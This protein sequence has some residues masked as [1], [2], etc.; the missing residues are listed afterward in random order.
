MILE[1][2]W[3]TD[4]SQ[5]FS[6][7]P[8]FYQDVNQVHLMESKNTFTAFSLKEGKELWSVSEGK[9]LFAHSLLC[10][11]FFFL[12]G[13]DIFSDQED[14]T[15]IVD[16]EGTCLKIES[17]LWP[18]IFDEKHVADSD[19]NVFES[20]VCV[21]VDSYSELI[22]K[23]KEDG[24]ITSLYES[25]TML[26]PSLKQVTDDSFI[27]YIPIATQPLVVSLRKDKNYKLNYL[28][29]GAPNNSNYKNF[30]LIKEEK[31]NDGFGIFDL[32]NGE[33]L[34]DIE[35]SSNVNELDGKIYFVA[36]ES[37]TIKVWSRD[38]GVEDI[39]LEEYGVDVIYFFTEKYIIASTAN[40][41]RKFNIYF[42]NYDGSLVHHEVF[43]GKGF[44][45]YS[46]TSEYL[47][48]YKSNAISIYS[49]ED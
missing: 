5:R 42:Y 36:K 29:K 10:N 25:D 23:L 8:I 27:V 43:D 15:L 41:Q 6:D 24:R 32:D 1:K 17:K 11:K 7:F 19:L 31:D 44:E 12:I 3:S 34:G 14:E 22:E 39:V 33:K 18:R 26:Y 47:A 38:K 48:I 4:F 13:Y 30:L 49:I 28:I 40:T 45:V 35:F 2:L 20:Q 16:Q 9:S 37:Y 21:K 46:A